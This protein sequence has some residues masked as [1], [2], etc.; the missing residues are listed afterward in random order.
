VMLNCIYVVI[1][2]TGHLVVYSC[3]AWTKTE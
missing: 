1:P 2:Y 3:L